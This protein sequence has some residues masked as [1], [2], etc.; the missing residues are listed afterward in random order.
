MDN[1]N[2]KE[3]IQ[4]KMG[5][6]VHITLKSLKKIFNL[7]QT[8]KDNNELINDVESWELG[9]LGTLP[10]INNEVLIL[11]IKLCL[12]LDLKINKNVVFDRKIYN[13]FDL[14]KGFQITQQ[15]YPIGENGSLPIFIDN[16]VKKISISRVQLE[17]DTA[18]SFYEDSEVSLDFNRSGNPLIELVTDPVFNDIETLISFIKQLQNLLRYLDISEA[19]M[20]KGQFRMDLNFSFKFSD[21]YQTPRYEIKNLNSLKNLKNSVD[22]EI[23]KHY[24]IFKNRTKINSP[25]K[26]ET[27]SFNEKTQKTFV[28]REKTKYF[29]LPEIN[30]PLIKINDKDIDKVKENLPISPWKILEKITKLQNNKNC[31]FIFEKPFLLKFINLLEK[32]N[33]YY[34][35]NFDNLVIFFFNHLIPSLHCFND[36]EIFLFFEKNIDSIWKIFIYW[37][38]KIISK[39]EINNFISMI[40]SEKFSFSDIEN[41]IKNKLNENKNFNIEDLQKEIQIILEENSINKKI[42]SQPS[43]LSNFFFGKLKSKF[44]NR[45]IKFEDI[46]YLSTKMS[47]KNI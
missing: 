18:K 31:N 30:I 47:E 44:P 20:E 37:K 43:K 14:S 28:Q 35:E 1:D 8:F 10:I 12:F 36:E 34:L 7:N 22:Q 21:D 39:I 3:K 19:K 5:L 41:Q 33:I 40:L 42:I 9:Y 2:I 27:L 29:Y 15:R 25:L 23:E 32:R 13:Y 26:S 17:E 16:Q 45:I 4:I 24:E 11:A 38:D 46:N 6:E